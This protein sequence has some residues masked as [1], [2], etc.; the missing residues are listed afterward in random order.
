MPVNPLTVT[1]AS[2]THSGRRRANQD[3]VEV[4]RLSTGA[5]LIAVADGMGGHAAGEVAS[6]TALDVLVSELERGSALQAA[7]AAA[8]EAVFSR[9]RERKEWSGMGTTLV[10]VL[11][12][13]DNYFVSNVGDSRAYR[14]DADSIER[15]TTDHSFVEE[16]VTRGAMTIAQAEASPWKNAL[17]RAVGTDAEVEVDI[18]GPFPLTPPHAVL[19][20]SDGL[21]RS[22]SDE[23]IREYV[24][25][26]DDLQTATEALAALAYRR[27]SD[28]NISIALV[29]FESLARRLPTVT[30]P[31]PIRL[32][33]STGG[34]ERNAAGSRGDGD[35]ARARTAPRDLQPLIAAAPDRR[36]RPVWW[37]FLLAGLITL[38]FVTWSM[39]SST[40]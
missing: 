8:N 13:D 12:Q 23:T 36:R 30:L 16:A 37:V 2:Y 17:T 5:E 34:L 40:S 38:L 19:L 33:E 20:C 21:Y 39:I 25:S 10:A 35:A 1:V 4:R 11:K 14:I 22:V 26:T 18:F 9:S 6:A 15:I 31:L 28:D 24:L 32:Q 27:G 29:E 3:A 7:V